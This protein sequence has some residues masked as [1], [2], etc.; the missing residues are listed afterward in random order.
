MKNILNTTLLLLLFGTALSAQI[1]DT[2][3]PLEGSKLKVIAKLSANGVKLRWAPVDQDHWMYVKDKTFNIYRA[4]FTSELPS[5]DKYELIDSVGLLPSTHFE[6]IIDDPSIDEYYK[7][8]GLAAYGYWETI[9][10]G[11][12]SFNNWG[13]RV[14]EL[15][16][17]YLTSMF[18]CDMNFEAAQ[19]VGF[20][21]FDNDIDP[22]KSHA[23][24]IEIAGDN[25]YKSAYKVVRPLKKQLKIMDTPVLSEGREKENQIVLRWHRND[26]KKYTAFNIERSSD[27]KNYQKLNK[28][29]YINALT[30]DYNELPFII[31]MDSVQNYT[32]YYYRIIGVDAFGDESKPSESQL[33]M[34]RDRTSP[35][36]AWIDSVF[37]NPNQTAAELYWHF[38]EKSDDLDK[39][40]IKKGPQAAG[41]YYPIAEINKE[42]QQFSD[43]DFSMRHLQYY[44]VCAVDTAGNENCGEGSY[45]QMRDRLPPSRPQNL[46][47]E[48]DSSGIVSLTWNLGAE[49]DIFGYYVQMSNGKGRVF[50][51]LTDIALRDT[52][53]Q[54]TITLH[55]LT[56]SIYYRITA[57]DL[58]DNYSPF[59]EIIKLSKPDTIPP[60]PAVF[61]GYKVEE[62]HVNL[63]FSLSSSS[64]VESTFLVKKD[65]TTGTEDRFLLDRKSK[66]YMD[67]KIASDSRYRYDLLVIDDAGH[68]TYSPQPI[69]IH[70]K[71]MRS[72][73]E[74]SISHKSQEN[75]LTITLSETMSELKHIQLYTGRTAENQLSDKKVKEIQQGKINL[76]LTSYQDKYVKLRCYY[77]GGVKSKYSNVILIK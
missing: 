60:R 1:P 72:G 36:A 52:T 10:R 31:Y 9:K 55:T 66:N 76:D 17:R 77:S 27:K 45:C 33:L 59:S 13:Q 49:E 12:S 50:T 2:I 35:M 30:N 7:M 54:D 26:H 73:H 48:I 20:A 63:D 24:K 6:K 25:K 21:Y 42:N 4:S 57:V 11:K 14:Q 28:K 68:E 18:C 38:D 56:E 22:T 62:E 39:L 19:A 61:K 32:P 43:K 16:S 8:A 58:R 46:K 41:P 69:T 29:P 37:I 53:W 47:G 70:T 71:D 3:I 34:G 44:Q 64:D 5:G 51:P 15:E 75:I 65:L 23:Y 74:L 40:I 67:I